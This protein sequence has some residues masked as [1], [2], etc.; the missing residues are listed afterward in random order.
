M[1][2]SDTG[3]GPGDLTTRRPTSCPN[4]HNFPIRERVGNRNDHAFDI[5][6]FIW[7]YDRQVGGFHGSNPNC[8]TGR[9]GKDSTSVKP[10]TLVRWRQRTYLAKTRTYCA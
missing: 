4:K 6:P 10:E 5:D 8:V 3:I 7:D 2:A 1:K 9:P